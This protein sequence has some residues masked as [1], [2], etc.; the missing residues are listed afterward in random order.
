MARKSLRYIRPL[1][2]TQ[3][4]VERVE[5]KGGSIKGVLWAIDPGAIAWSDLSDSS[6]TFNRSSVVWGPLNDAHI[7]SRAL[8]PDVGK[9]SVPMAIR[10][11][12]VG[13][14]RVVRTHKVLACKDPS[15]KG[16]QANIPELS[17]TGDLCSNAQSPTEMTALGCL[18]RISPFFNGWGLSIKWIT[19]VSPG[20]GLP[21]EGGYTFSTSRVATLVAIDQIRTSPW[22]SVGA[23]SHSHSLGLRS[24]FDHE[25]YQNPQQ[26]P[27]VYNP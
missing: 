26:V 17:I 25:P 15:A 7:L 27:W 1:Y 20:I 19:R 11:R 3:R 2:A 24:H 5:A 4:R 14:K 22:K 6:N 8:N 16:N 12:S 13:P 18:G 9:V 23:V 21:R 10:H